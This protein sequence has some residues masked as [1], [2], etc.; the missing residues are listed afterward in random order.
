V[1]TVTR[2]VPSKGFGSFQ[3]ALGEILRSHSRGRRRQEMADMAIRGRL[4]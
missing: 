3:A 4:S 1:P 2:P